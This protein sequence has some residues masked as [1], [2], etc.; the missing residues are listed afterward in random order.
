MSEDIRDGTLTIQG[1]PHPLGGGPWSLGAEATGLRVLDTPA[2]VQVISAISLTGILE[3]MGNTGLNIAK[4]EFQG[5]LA[6][7][8]LHIQRL[9]LDGPSLV[10]RWQGR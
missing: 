8:A 9:K 4:M 7:P 6:T 5:T 1:D 3:Q 10:F 2:L